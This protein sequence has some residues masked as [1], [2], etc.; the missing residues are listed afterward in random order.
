MYY[1]VPVRFNKVPRTIRRKELIYFTYASVSILIGRYSLGSKSGVMRR[2]KIYSTEFGE[3]ESHTVSGLENVSLN[4][5]YLIPPDTNHSKLNV[6]EGFMYGSVY[7][8]AGESVKLSQ[9]WRECDWW[10]GQLN[11]KGLATLLESLNATDPVILRRNTMFAGFMNCH[12]GHFLVETLP[13]LWLLIDSSLDIVDVVV[14]CLD[15]NVA[16]EECHCLNMLETVVKAVRTPRSTKVRTYFISN[17]VRFQGSLYVPESSWFLEALE[18]HIGAAMVFR[19]VSES[20]HGHQS[21]TIKR[22]TKG[23]SFDGLFLLRGTADSMIH[24]STAINQ[25]ELA[26]LFAASMNLLVVDPATLTFAEQVSLISR[27]KILVG[28]YGSGM[29]A[30]VFL[31]AGSGVI[32]VEDDRR[33]NHT[34][35]KLMKLMKL[36]GIT[37][38]F[39]GNL[40]P[41]TRKIEFNISFYEQWILDRSPRLK[42]ENTSNYDLFKWMQE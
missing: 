37:I 2:E 33:I 13:R 7:D 32:V 42:D 10:R 8:M 17:P 29:H 14:F 39:S 9:R 3:W 16:S 1:K 6:G 15:G 18:F 21:D 19:R 41:E 27:S 22:L 35:E 12:Y 31:P 25:A 40:Y 36:D 5:G 20:M 26:T 24:S 23:K 38:P 4:S 28:R 11:P 30:C 34:Q